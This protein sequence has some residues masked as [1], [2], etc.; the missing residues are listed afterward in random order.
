[1][2]PKFAYHCW[3]RDVS[4]F[5]MLKYRDYQGFMVSMQNSGTQWL[6]HMMS[7]ALALKYDVPPPK[8]VQN[9]LSNELIGHPKHKRIHPHLPRIASSH[10]IPHILL[11]SPLLHRFLRFPRYVVLVRDIRAALVSHYEKR[12]EKYG[13]PFSEYLHGDPSGKRF[14]VDIW[15]YLHFMNRWGAVQASLPGEV[16]VVRYEELRRDTEVGL[17]EV[18]RHIGIDMPDAIITAAV[19][20][21]SKEKMARKVKQDHWHQGVVRMDER[22]PLTWFGEE[23][24]RFFTATL[25]ENARYTLGYSYWSD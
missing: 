2:D 6:K 19:A 22:D 23:D 25:A 18:F 9:E 20:E 24:I 10:S 21:S 13:I 1:M 8:Y 15:W 11:G 4:N 12:K 14:Q 3:R 16:L 17:R 7:N 5:A